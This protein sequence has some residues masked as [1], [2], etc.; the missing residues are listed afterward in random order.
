MRDRAILLVVL[1]IVVCA[2]PATGRASPSLCGRDLE[3][4]AA[5]SSACAMGIVDATSVVVPDCLAG[6]ECLA[7]NFRALQTCDLPPGVPGLGPVVVHS[8]LAFGPEDVP[9][10]FSARAAFDGGVTPWAHWPGM[11]PDVDGQSCPTPWQEFVVTTA[12]V[13]DLAIPVALTE[14]CCA[15][16]HTPYDPGGCQF[17]LLLQIAPAFPAGRW[18]GLVSTAEPTYR[19]ATYRGGAWTFPYELGLPGD[20]RLW[21]EAEYCEHPTPAAGASWG[22]IKTLYR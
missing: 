11:P 8:L 12:G 20:I 22:A 17:N 21:A 18:P 19:T 2:V 13:L 6:D 7:V 3:P 4:H 1:A 5:P 16:I 15:N 9:V 14:N 10:V